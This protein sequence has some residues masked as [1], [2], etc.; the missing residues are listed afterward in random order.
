[1]FTGAGGAGNEALWQLLG[2][3]YTLHFGDADLLA[4]D[5]SIPK[6]RRHQ[7]PWASDPDF[8]G[9]MANLCRRLSID[10]LVPGVDEELLA[11]ARN[12]N[13]L[14]PTLLLLP[15][16]DY[17]ETM[18]DKLH[19]V[20]SLADKKIPVPLSR[21]LSDNLQGIRF[22]CISKPRRGRGSRDVR[23]LNSLADAMFLNS[24]LGYAAEKI[25]VQ[26]NV[27]GVEYTVQMVAD[28]NGRLCAVVPVR[29][30]IKRGITIRAET[31][32]EPRVIA[33]CR[34]IHQAIPAGG[35]YN[36]QLMLTAEGKVLPFEI[37]PRVSTTLCLAVA[38]GID[39]IAVFL[40]HI[41]SD[42]L[43]PVTP[44]IQLRRHWTN[45]FSSRATV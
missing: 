36:I 11:L 9:K 4:I 40:G 13:A 1:M 15:H 39:P 3:H 12:A 43:L 44:G 2:Q 30:G 41:Q 45:H 26:D 23:M 6:D 27:E 16:A 25:L 42:D 5:P 28:A 18:L 17:V 31:E 35:C 22:P 8:V 14:A 24:T 34:A 7:L 29:V 20:R 21:I 19:M 33:A 10:L 38:A 32:A 37:N